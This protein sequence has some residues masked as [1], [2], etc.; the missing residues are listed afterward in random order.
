MSTTKTTES[1]TKLAT[2]TLVW[3]GR[4]PNHAKHEKAVTEI[5]RRFAKTTRPNS[6][7]KLGAFLD[8]Y[9]GNEVVATEVP[10]TVVAQIVFD[11]QEELD[12]FVASR[13]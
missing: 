5:R 9:D 1:V 12:A 6:I 4:R 13:A 7:A 11:S 10:E 8:A 3:L 2:S